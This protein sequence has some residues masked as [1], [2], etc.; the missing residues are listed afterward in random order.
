MIPAEQGRTE[1]KARRSGPSLLC[2]CE[3]I[4]GTYDKRLVVDDLVVDAE[5][6]VQETAVDGFDLGVIDQRSVEFSTVVQIED[7]VLQILPILER[8]TCQRRTVELR[9]RWIQ[10]AREA[11]WLGCS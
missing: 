2:V 5:D 7:A 1:Q 11:L 4:Y 8:I 6:V 10:F 3:A 9:V